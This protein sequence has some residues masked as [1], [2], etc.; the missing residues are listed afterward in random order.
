VNTLR[1]RQIVVIGEGNIG[2]KVLKRKIKNAPRFAFLIVIILLASVSLTR[3]A[4][5]AAPAQASNGVVRAVLFWMDGCPHC[6][7]VL[8]EILPPLQALYGDKLDILLIEVKS[9]EELDRLYLL[10]ESIGIP[11][12]QVGVPFMLIGEEVL[13]G[14]GQIPA[15]LPRLISVYLAAGGVDYPDLPALASFLP[16]GATNETSD[17]ILTPASNETPVPP[18]VNLLLLWT[19][20]CHACQVVVSQALPPLKEKYG[21]QLVVHY[22]DVVTGEDVDHFYQVA[23]AFGIPQDRA[24]LPMLIVGD[25]VLIG[26]EQIPAELPELVEKYLAAGGVALP[27]TTQLVKA[28]S[29]ADPALSGRPD[30]FNLAIGMLVFG[31]VGLLYSIAAVL[32][33]RKLLPTLQK[34]WLDTVFIVL[35]LAGL[36]VALYLAYVETQ[37]VSAVCGPVGD[38]NAVQSSPYARLFGVLPVGVLGVI[39]YLA[40]LAAWIYPRLRSDWLAQVAP[41]LV[42][43]MTFMG[44]I[45]SLYL[46]YLEPFVIKAVCIWCLTSAV[47]MTLLLLL[48]ITPARQA[49]IG[50]LHAQKT[51]S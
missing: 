11:K 39:G 15:E 27:D 33:E 13:I 48:S 5:A 37:A 21:E 42:F 40:I 49:L 16:T 32:S 3:P 14:S 8:D 26:A 23:A 29:S 46:T 17:P 51:S 43:G 18:I 47:I 9:M 2:R 31:P 44:V 45:F 7:K 12:E 4:R 50:V 19:S 36:G 30:G 1:N 34:R 24:D 22:V 6:H 20:D 41:L 25:N 28:N 35:V 38:C 10:A